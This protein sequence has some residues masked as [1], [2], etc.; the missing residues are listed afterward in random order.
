MH[1]ASAHHPMPSRLMNQRRWNEGSREYCVRKRRTA[2]QT[3]GRE[4]RFLGQGQHQAGSKG[5]CRN[6]KHRTATRRNRVLERTGH[7]EA[8][9]NRIWIMKWRNSQGKTRKIHTS[10]SESG[11]L[12]IKDWRTHL[13][14]RQG[15]TEALLVR[16]MMDL[17][18]DVV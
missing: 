3:V 11:R 6:E 10:A 4:G 12:G 7:S 2:S 13:S 14:A 18:R 9:R 8:P 17:L 1:L 5:G 15:A 16:T